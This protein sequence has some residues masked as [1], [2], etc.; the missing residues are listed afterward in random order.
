MTVCVGKRHTKRTWREF[1]AFVRFSNRPSYPYQVGAAA[2]LVHGNVEI[3]KVASHTRNPQKSAKWS[4]S[5][6]LLFR[7]YLVVVHL[8]PQLPANQR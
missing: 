7:S 2:E 3:G 6:S 1:Y 4:R 5:C 8:A